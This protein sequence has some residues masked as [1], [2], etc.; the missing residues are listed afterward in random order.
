MKKI[1]GIILGV[2]MC[3]GGVYC[4]MTPGLAFMSLGVVFAITLIES[5][6]ANFV[7]WYKTRHLQLNNTALLLNAI[8]SLIAGILLI[9]N[10][11]TQLFVESIMLYMIAIVMIARGIAQIVHAFDIKK[12]IP[13]SKWVLNLICGILVTISG[14]F[15]IVNPL[16]LSL[17]IGII[18]AI[19]IFTTGISLVVLSLSI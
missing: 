11:F 8:M 2:L 13:G 6:I 18:I 7:I 19:N 10:Q 3:I 14:I 15:S 5:A 1:L 12:F 17:A 16:V 9:T 4:L